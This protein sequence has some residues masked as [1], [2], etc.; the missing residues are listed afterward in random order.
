MPLS[1]L[2]LKP[3]VAAESETF[4]IT[5]AISRKDGALHLCFSLSGPLD[6]LRIPLPARHPERRENLWQESCFEFFL[7]ET[8]SEIYREI[9]IALSGHWNVFHFDCYR[10][11]MRRKENITSLPCR[12]THEPQ[13]FTLQTTLDLDLMER[14]D[15]PLQIG[16]SAVLLSKDNT[17]SYWALTHPAEKPDFH[18]RRGF[19]LTL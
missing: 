13:L 4:A 15:S 7:A 17:L 5:C 8:D 1:S 12:I 6:Q 9:N 3:F 16:M 14:A 19:L 11:G 10:Q 2:S 18:D